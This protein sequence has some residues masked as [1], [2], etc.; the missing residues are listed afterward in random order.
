MDFSYET[1]VAFSKSW[2][3]FYMM[4]FFLCVCAYALWPKNRQRFDRAK[5]SILERDDTPCQK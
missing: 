4:A 5:N 1:V 3:L 2:G